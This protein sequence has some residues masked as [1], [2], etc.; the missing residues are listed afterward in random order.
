MVSALV[1]DTLVFQAILTKLRSDDDDHRIRHS[2]PIISAEVT[3]ALLAPA[4]MV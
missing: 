2:R 1:P 3:G 4:T